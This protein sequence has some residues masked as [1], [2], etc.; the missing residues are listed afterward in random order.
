MWKHTVGKIL[1]LINI[2]C[3]SGDKLILNA[4]RTTIFYLSIIYI[5]V[6]IYLELCIHSMTTFLT[7]VVSTNQT[8]TAQI[9]PVR[10]SGII[11]SPLII[12]FNLPLCK[13]TVGK[14]S[15]LT[16]KLCT[17]SKDNVFKCGSID[18]SNDDGPN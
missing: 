18:E 2:R 3:V 14:I 13:N 1:Q 17:H 8:M 6:F 11:R 16:Q 5:H 9:K 4:P 10:S 12:Y 7:L 15:Q